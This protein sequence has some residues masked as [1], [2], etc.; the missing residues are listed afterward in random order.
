VKRRRL[1]IASPA[2][3]REAKRLRAR[4]HGVLDEADQLEDA[5]VAKVQAVLTELRRKLLDHAAA[6]VSQT[7]NV[8]HLTAGAERLVEESERELRRALVDAQAAALKAGAASVRVLVEPPPEESQARAQEARPRDRLRADLVGSGNVVSPG[9]RERMDKLAEAE[10]T[11]LASTMKGQIVTSLQRAAL[12]GLSPLEAMAAVDQALPAA[13]RGARLTTGVGSS[14]ERIV[15]TQLGRAFAVSADDNRAKLEKGLGVVLDVEWVATTDLRTR[16]EHLAMHGV[17]ARRD[18]GF[19]VRIPGKGGKERLRYPGDPQ[20]KPSNIIN[21]RCRATT[22]LPDDPSL[23]Y[24]DDA[25][26]PLSWSTEAEVAGRPALPA[27]ARR[28]GVTDVSDRPSVA[29]VAETRKQM[30]LLPPATRKFL[31]ERNVDFQVYNKTAGWAI[32]ATRGLAAATQPQRG[33]KGTT[34]AFDGVGH[35][36]PLTSTIRLV[37]VTD[38]RGKTRILGGTERPGET[39]AHEIGHAYEYGNGKGHPTALDWARPYVLGD[40]RRTVVGVDGERVLVDPAFDDAYVSDLGSL[41]DYERQENMET[42]FSET[43]A[44]SFQMYIQDR[45]KLKRDRPALYAWFKERFGARYPMLRTQ[46]AKASVRETE[47]QVHDRSYACAC[48][49]GCPGEAWLNADESIGMRLRDNSGIVHWMRPTLPTE[50]DYARTR[51]HIENHS[52]PMKVGEK[53]ALRPFPEKW[54]D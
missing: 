14:A 11:S 28:P 22:K 52:G 47:G 32:V 37:A 10:V 20:G 21:C 31:K 35:F 40:P 45:K 54:P 25:D 16:P 41:T 53:Y 49:P 18:E 48:P 46:K 51:A 44:T 23:L 9:L 50:G 38:E 26:P 24:P 12:S 2:R 39:I 13:D 34:N 7:P 33:W 15:R 5:T 6:S 17:V 36:D 29:Q 42:S 8:A 43:Y 27:S 3:T 4:L 19:E 1:P 30:R